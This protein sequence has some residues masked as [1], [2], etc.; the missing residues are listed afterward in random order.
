MSE[1]INKCFQE[2]QI[3]VILEIRTISQVYKD[4][5]N[6]QNSVGNDLSFC[7]LYNPVHFQHLTRTKHAENEHCCV[8]IKKAK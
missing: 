2:Q 1:N 4:I 3:F 6:L 7:I 5:K 8:T